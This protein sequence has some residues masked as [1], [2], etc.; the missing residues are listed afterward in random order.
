MESKYSEDFRKFVLIK[1]YLA[2][3]EVFDELLLKIDLLI[4]S[5]FEYEEYI[6]L[7]LLW[8]YWLYYVKGHRNE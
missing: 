2:G 7:S 3:E 4:V 5:D 1:K 8:N 6:T